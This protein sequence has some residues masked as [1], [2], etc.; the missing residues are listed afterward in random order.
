[1]LRTMAKPPARDARSTA[2]DRFARARA[3]DDAAA[4]II[5]SEKLARDKKTARLRELRL[6]RDATAS[7]PVVDKKPTRKKPT[8]RS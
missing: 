8:K 2:E 4:E 3:S 1:M 7:L 6:A 5:A